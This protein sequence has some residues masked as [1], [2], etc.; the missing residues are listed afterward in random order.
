M[1]SNNRLITAFTYRLAV[2]FFLLSFLAE[3]KNPPSPDNKSAAKDTVAPHKEAEEMAEAMHGQFSDQAVLKFDSLEIKDFFSKYPL[4]SSYKNDVS[5]FYSKRSYSFA[6]YDNNGMIEQAGNFYSRLSNFSAEGVDAKVPY[7]QELDSLMASTDATEKKQEIETEVLLSG[8]YFYFANK[9]WKGLDNSATDKIGWYL[10]RKKIAYAQLLDSLLKTSDAFNHSREPIYRQYG[11]LKSYLK[12]YREIENTANWEQIKAD[13]KSYRLNDSSIVIKK[14]KAKLSL[15]GDLTIADSTVVFDSALEGAV[16]NFQHRY[17]LTED[18]II[19]QSM[20]KDL[21]APLQDKIEK[22]LVNMERSRWLPM[23]VSGEYFAV[24]IP[25]FRLHA[26][27]GDSSLWDMNVVVG[28]A[29]SKTTI[30]SGKLKYVVFSPY[31]NVP[32]SIYKHEVLPGMQRN[33]NY[34]AQHHMERTSDGVRQVPGP[35]NSLGKVKFLFPNSYSIYFH[36]TP[37][38]SLFGESRRD[39]SHG[40]IRLAEPKKMATYLLRNDAA[41]DDNKITAA[42]NANKEKYVTLS[43]EIPVFITYLTAWVDRS[44]QLN[45]RNDIYNRD[46]RLMEMMMSSK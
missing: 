25:E 18:G 7:L 41:W 20:I 27:N 2:L 21:N 11:L 8:L 29:A 43:K 40:C 32:A 19:G 17:G 12:K 31:W 28:K 6:W 14:V 15:T 39:F 45:L 22:I 24:N 4:L 46:K 26:F 16:K 44:G 35:W 5:S 38:K 10:P 33:K 23:A 42:M 13:K 34:L 30:F 36:D 9:V 3:C 37:S 1:I